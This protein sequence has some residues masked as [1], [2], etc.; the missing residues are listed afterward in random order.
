MSRTEVLEGL[1]TYK[2]PATEG[3]GIPYEPKKSTKSR[4]QSTSREI[5]T[6]ITT[7]TLLM[8]IPINVG[9]RT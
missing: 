2:K 4:S 9:P 3:I 7:P 1:S 6:T 8:K 5:S